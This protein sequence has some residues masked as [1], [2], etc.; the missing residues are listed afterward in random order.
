MIDVSDRAPLGVLEGVCGRG[1]AEDSSE[2]GSTGT[3]GDLSLARHVSRWMFL[4]VFGDGAYLW[5]MQKIYIAI[6]CFLSLTTGHS[7]STQSKETLTRARCLVQQDTRARVKAASNFRSPTSIL[8]A[9]TAKQEKPRVA[10]QV[11]FRALS[12]RW[13]SQ[14]DTHPDKVLC[15]RVARRRCG[16]YTSGAFLKL[17]CPDHSSPVKALSKSSVGAGSLLRRGVTKEELKR[18]ETKA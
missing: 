15:L 11:W 1:G 10:K 4:G 7:G 18:Q 8:P 2:E 5:R 17:H 16:R 12:F 14:K 3:L 6:A 13:A 9:G